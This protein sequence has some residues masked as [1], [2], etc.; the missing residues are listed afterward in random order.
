MAVTE[1]FTAI[2]DVD[3][4][5]RNH[6]PARIANLC[7]GQGWSSIAL[8]HTYAQVHIDGFDRDADAINAAWANAHALGLTDRLTF[9]VYDVEEEWLNGRY[10]LVV[11]IDCLSWMK[12]PLAALNTMHRLSGA[13][14]M[15]VVL[16]LSTAEQAG[17]GSGAHSAPRLPADLLWRYAQIAGFQWVERI[18]LKHIGYILYRL[19]Q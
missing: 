18:P 17:E 13:D 6:P 8:A 4:R 3:N 11:A 5:L 10:D 14:G 2:T 12:N 9:H 16:N 1:W 15:A 7:C 19:F